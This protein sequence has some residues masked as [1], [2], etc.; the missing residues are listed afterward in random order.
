MRKNREVH[1]SVKYDKAC[2]RI[3][4]K[5]NKLK[6]HIVCAKRK[7]REMEV[8]KKADRAEPINIYKM[9]ST[10]KHVVEAGRWATLQMRHAYAGKNE[11]EVRC[12]RKKY[13]RCSG[14]L[15]KCV[16]ATAVMVGV[17]SRFVR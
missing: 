17:V 8:D 15:G 14:D 4:K 10:I 2:M 7:E 11:D 5:K 1:E 12:A 16:H 9:R 13:K 6:N 3:A